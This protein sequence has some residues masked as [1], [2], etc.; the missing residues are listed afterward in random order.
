MGRVFEEL[1]ADYLGVAY[2]EEALEL[3]RTGV[4]IP[5]LVFGGLLEEQ[6]D[7]Y[8]EH[9]ID[10]TASSVSK[11]EQIDA[12]AARMGR[13]ARV[14]LKID[15]GL[16]RIGVHYYTAETLFEAALRVRHAEIVGVYSH[17]ADVDLAD[18]SLTH[19][20]LERFLS[21]LAYFES[22]ATGPFLR[23][24]AASGG[25]IALPASHLDMIRPGLALYGVYPGPG[26]E[27]LLP[28][29][30]TLTLKSR[31]VFFKVVRQ[32]AG[33]SYGH[34]WHA[35]HD[36]RIVTIP[37]GYGDGYSRQLSN[38]ASVLIR[39]K[40]CRVVGVVCMDQFMVDLG[41]DG[42]AFNRDEVVL[43]GSQGG[44]R[45]SV[46]ELAGLMNT[47]PHEVLVLLNQRIPRV[48]VGSIGN[49]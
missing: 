49:R 39:N 8:I 12:V 7:L 31:V 43:I 26:F 18:L 9:D 48:Y 29:E 15:T 38:K 46:E 34:K 19:I 44:E 1:Q 23:H 30:P 10:V 47:T 22:R 42:E 37:V 41:P 4:T 5:I 36:T 40:R 13:R 14:H 17:F 25:A 32:G 16:E 28:L 35:P 21:A 27:S 24:I 6:L 2:I 11:L 33:V 45:V 20:Q 3:R